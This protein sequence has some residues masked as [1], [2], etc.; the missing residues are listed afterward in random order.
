MTDDGDG[1]Y[2]IAAGVISEVDEMM[3]RDKISSKN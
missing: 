1:T 3:N 2:L